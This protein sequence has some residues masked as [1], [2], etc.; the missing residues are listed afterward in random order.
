[1]KAPKGEAGGATEGLRG[2]RVSPCDPQL[3]LNSSKHACSLREPGPRAFATDRWLNDVIS[4]QMPF[5][6]FNTTFQL[7]PGP[8]ASTHSRHCNGC[9][10]PVHVGV[11]RKD[12]AR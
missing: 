8:P 1:M 12:Q 3:C 4:V 6:H 7:G 9:L 11:E 10:L 5:W 2:G